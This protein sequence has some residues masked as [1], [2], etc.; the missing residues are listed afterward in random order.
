MNEEESG[1]FTYQFVYSNEE[2]LDEMVDILE[3]AIHEIEKIKG[4]SVHCPD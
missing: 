3:T 4:A 1:Y 2:V